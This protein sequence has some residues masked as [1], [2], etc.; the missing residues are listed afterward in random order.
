[1]TVP[2]VMAEWRLGVGVVAEQLISINNLAR[3]D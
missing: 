1:M 3:A 2:R